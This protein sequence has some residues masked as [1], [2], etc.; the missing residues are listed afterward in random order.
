MSQEKIK[1][2]VGQYRLLRK[3]GPM[4]AFFSLVIQPHGIKYID[5]RYFVTEDGRKWFTFPQKEIPPKEG[6]MKKQYIPYVSILDREY[7]EALKEAVLTELKN[8]DDKAVQD[9]N[10]AK[11]SGENGIQINASAPF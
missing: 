1:V 8:A 6:E 3:D 2:E 9:G 5:C 10:Q 7:L 11:S 4:R